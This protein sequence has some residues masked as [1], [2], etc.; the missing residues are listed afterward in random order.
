MMPNLG[1]GGCQAI[2][3][4]CVLGEELEKCTERSQVRF[5]FYKIFVHSKAFLH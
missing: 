3:D 2:E 5:G 1:Q 4:A